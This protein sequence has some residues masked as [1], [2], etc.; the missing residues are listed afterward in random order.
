MRTY[1]A[2]TQ[3]L[4]NV[5]LQRVG[6]TAILAQEENCMTHDPGNSDASER[7]AAEDGNARR[8]RDLARKPGQSQD[9]IRHQQDAAHHM[10]AARPAKPADKNGQSN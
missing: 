2:P 6:E 5:R 10:N 8:P 3:F 9:A 4:A 1:I 7:D